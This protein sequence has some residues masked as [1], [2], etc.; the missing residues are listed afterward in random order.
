[1]AERI[2]QNPHLEVLPNHAGPRY[3]A[4]RTLLTNTGLSEAEAAQALNNTWT[5]AHED[6][7]VAWDQQVRDDAEAE[8]AAMHLAQDHENELLA[9]KERDLETERREAEKKKPKMNDFD[10]DL[11]IED[12]IIPRPA[13]YALRRLDEFEYVELWYFSQEGCV[14][15]S[16]NQ[17]TQHEDT[18]GLTKVDEM[19]SLRPVASLKASKNVI[20]DV[21]LTWRQMTIARTTFIQQITERWPPKHVNALALFFMNIE[22]H[23]YRLRSLGERSLISYQARARRNWHDQLKLN[24][25][26]N[27]A[28]VNM[29][30]LQDI[31]KEVLDGEQINSI[32]EVSPS[33]FNNVVSHAKR[34]PLPTNLQNTFSTKNLLHAPCFLLHATC[35]MLHAT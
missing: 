8:E 29:N 15:A 30:L 3:D 35:Y 6:R 27:I 14:D 7:I 31:H 12:F 5:M 9:Q 10:M 2:A 20:Q 21:D 34:S 32:K 26:F 23:P 28:N 11:S 16:A 25:A 18:F 4:L 13:A 19:L 17:R 22:T 33:S 24:K 1:M